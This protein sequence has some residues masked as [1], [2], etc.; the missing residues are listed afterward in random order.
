MH[1]P[2]LQKE[3]IEYLDPKPNEN[4][5]DCTV[6][7]AGHSLA[8]LENNGP[9]GKVLGID[10]DKNQIL[11]L[12]GI[13]RLILANDNFNNLKEIVKKEKFNSVSGIL[14]DLGM[15]SGHLEESGRGFSFLKKEPL[16][17]RYDLENPL[18]AEKILNYW[19]ESEMERILKEFGEERFSS[20][21]AREIVEQRKVRPI[22][23]TVQLI[24]ILKK[25]IPYKYQHQRIHFA[26]RTFQALRISVNNELNNL[27]Q[28]LP[29]A[30]E[31]LKPGGRLLI[32]SFHSLEDRIVKNFFKERSAV[33][34]LKIL[35]KKP[36]GPGQ[37]EIKINPRSRSAKLRAAIK[38]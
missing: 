22:K 24:E 5:I 32:I 1:I 14:F 9:K 36:I 31:I 38:Q 16:D 6:G 17:M 18:T 23:N 15:S 12:K 30:A 21:I 27:K 28:V 4:F 34:E 29:R 19:S 37:Q 35:T 3:V 7:E 2:V 20:Q 13:E 25:A 10:L 11:K 8:I 26:T 33:G